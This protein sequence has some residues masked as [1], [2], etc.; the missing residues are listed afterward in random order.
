VRGERGF[1]E[2]RK[3]REKGGVGG[4]KKVCIFAGKN[5]HAVGRFDCREER[6]GRR[7]K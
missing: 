1:G 7:W 2:G 5:K 6:G 3:K 4:K